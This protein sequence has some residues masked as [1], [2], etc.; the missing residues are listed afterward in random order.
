M[1]PD[2]NTSWASPRELA[3]AARMSASFHFFDSDFGSCL[4][5]D[6]C[7]YDFSGYRTSALLADVAVLSDD[8][9]MRRIKRICP[10]IAAASKLPAA[11]MRERRLAVPAVE[12][13]AHVH[14]PASRPIG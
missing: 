10:F 12:E 4:D 1:S 11:A 2:G 3:G 14:N 5:F 9:P 8:S 13:S 7:S 6:F